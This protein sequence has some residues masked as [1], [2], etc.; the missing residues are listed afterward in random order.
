MIITHNLNYDCKP[1]YF[2]MPMK[3]FPHMDLIYMGCK[4][5]NPTLINFPKL[6]LFL[7]FEIPAETMEDV[8]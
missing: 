8:Q 4:M 7:S 5:Y 6:D 1:L 3:D 2:E